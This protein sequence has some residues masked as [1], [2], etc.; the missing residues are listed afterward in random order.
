MGLS[1]YGK[2]MKTFLADEDGSFKKTSWTIEQ[3]KK[4]LKKYQ[5]VPKLTKR[6]E[7]ENNHV[8]SERT[9][10]KSINKKT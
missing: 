3:M 2:L 1:Q 4:T 6:H 8:G 9:P 5:K 10:W 7:E